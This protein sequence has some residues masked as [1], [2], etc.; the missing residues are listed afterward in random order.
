VQPELSAAVLNRKIAS[1]QQTLTAN[2]EATTIVT[3]NPG[4]LYQIRAGIR[5]NNIDIRILHPVVYMAER[6]A[7][8]C[9]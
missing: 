3:G 7:V 1:L 5:S 4:C 8:S 6:L 9:V 2:P